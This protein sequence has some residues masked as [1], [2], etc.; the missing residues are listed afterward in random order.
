[1]VVGDGVIAWIGGISRNWLSWKGCYNLNL[2]SWDNR[3]I[4]R[5]DVSIG[6]KLCCLIAIWRSCVAIDDK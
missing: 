6:K 5:H 1:M 3:L 2:W 4:L